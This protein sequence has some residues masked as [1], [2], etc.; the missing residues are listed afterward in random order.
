MKEDMH[1]NAV[2]RHGFCLSREALILEVGTISYPLFVHAIRENINGLGSYHTRLKAECDQT[3]TI[4]IVRIA[5]GQTGGNE[6]I[7]Q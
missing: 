6:F 7:T 1:V 3:Q 4:N 5:W 2:H